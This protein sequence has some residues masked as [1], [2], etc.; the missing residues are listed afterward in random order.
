MG[1]VVYQSASLEDL[2]E[3]IV[4]I[5]AVVLTKE[6]YEAVAEAELA[7]AGETS[8]EPLTE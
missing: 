5:D 8:E 7:E 2:A 1:N 3:E 6:D 4:E